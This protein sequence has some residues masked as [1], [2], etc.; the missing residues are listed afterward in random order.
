[1]DYFAFFGTGQCD[2]NKSL[3]QF[4][5]FLFF[6]TGWLV[7]AYNLRKI[8]TLNK[9]GKFKI[10]ISILLIILAIFTSI[11]L[12]LSVWLGLACGHVWLILDFLVQLFCCMHSRTILMDTKFR[13][14]MKK[15]WM[16]CHSKI[17]SIFILRDPF[18]KI[19]EPVK[20]CCSNQ[21][22]AASVVLNFS[23]ASEV[24]VLLNHRIK[25]RWLF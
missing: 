1:M 9:S 7:V 10:S 16:R 20:S 3:K 11:L 18:N 13:K 17:F 25:R 12:F 8:R 6:I 24:C 19:S 21:I 14:L 4:L 15:C 2:P 23:T 22:C 5:A